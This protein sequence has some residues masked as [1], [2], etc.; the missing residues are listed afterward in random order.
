MRVGIHLVPVLVSYIV[1]KA[2]SSPTT[3]LI[4]SFYRW[5]KWSL[6]TSSYWFIVIYLMHKLE[7]N[8]AAAAAKLLQSC[9]TLCNPIDSSPPGSSV[10]GILQARI[11]EWVAISFSNACMHAK[12]LQS[13]PF[14]SEVWAFNHWSQLKLHKQRNK[15]HE[16]RDIHSR[17]SSFIQQMY[18]RMLALCSS[19][20]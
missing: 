9:P 6:V 15:L 20:C 10:S 16:G 14:N 11:L 19:P 8:S 1:F 3:W 2:C 17:M 5:G 12:S 4:V 13:C 7:F 18:L